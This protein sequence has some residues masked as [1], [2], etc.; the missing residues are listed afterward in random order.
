MLIKIRT[1][2]GFEVPDEYNAMMGFEADH[3]D[4]RMSE[5]DYIVWY[6]KEDLYFANTKQEDE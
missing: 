4:F 1:D 3:P 2:I 6:T 5:T